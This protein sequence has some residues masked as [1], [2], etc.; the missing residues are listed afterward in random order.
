M[1]ANIGITGTGKFTVGILGGVGPRSSAELYMHIIQA[2]GL[3][4]S[5]NFPHLIISNL[6]VRDIISDLAHADE[7]AARIEL[8]IIALRRAGADSVVLACNT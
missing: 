1:S 8:E 2:V 6:P 7:S 5:E 4:A 3:V